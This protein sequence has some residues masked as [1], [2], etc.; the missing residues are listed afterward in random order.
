MEQMPPEVQTD[1]ARAKRRGPFLCVKNPT[2]RRVEA[3]THRDTGGYRLLRRRGGFPSRP[4]PS[5]TEAVPLYENA[6]S[7]IA[8]HS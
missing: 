7:P 3:R 2:D 5:D 8:P 6:I 4:T 1:G